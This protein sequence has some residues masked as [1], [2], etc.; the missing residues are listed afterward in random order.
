MTM[1]TKFF[2]RNTIVLDW[3]RFRYDKPG[4]DIT[5]H[6]FY[7]LFFNEKILNLRT[8]YMQ[9]KLHQNKSI[10][11]DV[12]WI[13]LH[14]SSATLVSISPRCVKVKVGNLSQWLEKAFKPYFSNHNYQIQFILCALY[15]FFRK[16]CT[17]PS[18]NILFTSFL[19]NK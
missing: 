18:S 15:N 13:R 10:G 12:H 8:H 19:L 11:N 3:I 1:I 6:C 9:V 4:Y 16:V 5:T 14:V 2:V 7:N 17:L